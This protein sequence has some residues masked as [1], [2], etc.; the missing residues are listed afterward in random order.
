MRRARAGARLRSTSASRPF[1]A[2]L[3]GAQRLLSAARRGSGPRRRRMASRS[4]LSSRP[5]SRSLGR[6]SLRASQGHRRG[7]A[8]AGAVSPTSPSAWDE[9]SRS[10]RRTRS[11]AHPSG[12]AAEPRRASSPRDNAPPSWPAM[13]PPPRAGQGHARRGIRRRRS[14]SRARSTPCTRSPR[15]LTG[16]ARLSHR[17]AGRTTEARR[18]RVRDAVLLLGRD[19]AAWPNAELALAALPIA[20]LALLDHDRCE[21]LDG[22]GARAAR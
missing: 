11:T 2:P 6:T 20:Q 1:A 10:T 21:E 4:P 8:L 3:H 19:P 9:W 17:C 5:S 12:R 15:A 18:Q 22:I 14:T 7:R 16:A 13:S